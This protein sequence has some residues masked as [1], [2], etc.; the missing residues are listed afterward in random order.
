M[1]TTTMFL[2][3]YTVGTDAYEEVPFITATYGSKAVVVG[4]KTAMEKA[5]KYLEEALDGSGTTIIEW[6][7]YGGNATYENVEALTQNPAVLEADMVFGMGGGRVLDAVKVLTSQ[8][9]KPFFSF[10]TIA[11][12]CA[13]CTQIAVMYNPDKTLNG[14]TF[15]DRPPHHTFIHTGVIA[16]APVPLLWA[17]IGDGLSKEPEVLLASR[18][19]ELGHTPY[20]GRVAARGCSEPFFKYGRKALK[21]CENN[22]VSFELE[23]VALDIIITTGLVSNLTTTAKDYYYNSSLGHAVYNGYAKLEDKLRTKEHLHGEV[24]SFG[25]LCMLVYDEQWEAF[26]AYQAFNASIG[27]PITMAEIELDE[28]ELEQLAENA[29]HVNEWRCAPYEISK[30]KF[31]AAI[32]EADRRGHA[33]KKISA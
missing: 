1:K 5:G 12:N 27:L 11:S 17:G 7:W 20:I 29:S 15:P 24:V 14:Y 10:P 21:D 18:D 6:V 31:I 9:K 32:L 22:E 25:V 23:Q 2:P 4:G 3:T 28:N 16:E 33:A 19:L 8:L 30:E 13:A 26:E